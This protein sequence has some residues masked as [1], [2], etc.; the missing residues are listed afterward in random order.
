M[1]GFWHMT[2]LRRKVRGDFLGGWK[3]SSWFR[4]PL[5]TD[6]YV[7]MQLTP[8][9]II[10]VPLWFVQWMC[11]NFMN[12]HVYVVL[13]SVRRRTT[14]VFSPRAGGVGVNTITTTSCDVENQT[15]LLWPE[16]VWTFFEKFT[17]RIE[18]SC[19]V[20]AARPLECKTLS[21][22]FVLRPPKASFASF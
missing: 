2:S 3:T 7:E 16:S 4:Y 8:R 22:Q 14:S 19:Q 12:W 1:P 18:T 20:S 21:E 17:S 9:R 15:K 6:H 10:S 5:C 13:V 11:S